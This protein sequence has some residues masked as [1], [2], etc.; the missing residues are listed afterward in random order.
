VVTTQPRGCPKAK[1]SSVLGEDLRP[2]ASGISENPVTRGRP[3]LQGPQLPARVCL[4]AL[5]KLHLDLQLPAGAQRCLPKTTPPAPPRQA[6]QGP[7]LAIGCALVPALTPAL[8]SPAPASVSRLAR[9][10]EGAGPN[11]GHAGRSPGADEAAPP[12]GT[13]TGRYRRHR[14]RCRRLPSAPCLRLGPEADAGRP[15][16]SPPWPRPAPPALWRPP[17]RRPGRPS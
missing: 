15:P 17:R 1:P 7:A 14:C 9:G 5:K 13:I 12:P 3:G 6:F 2:L 8:V 4:Q 10:G 11:S 16:S